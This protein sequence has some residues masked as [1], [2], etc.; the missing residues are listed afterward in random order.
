MGRRVGD[1]RWK[2]FGLLAVGLITLWAGPPF[3]SPA[4]A[5]WVLPSTRFGPDSTR[6]N[7]GYGPSDQISPLVPGSFDATALPLAAG[8]QFLGDA[9]GALRRDGFQLWETAPGQPPRRLA[10][11]VTATGW[12]GAAIASGGP[13][14][15][16]LTWA[17]PRFFSPARTWTVAISGH[18]PAPVSWPR[19]PLARQALNTVRTE[20]GESAVRY[21]RSLTLAAGRH[22]RYLAANGYQAPSFHRETAGQPEY[23]AATPWARDMMS[24]WP[25]PLTGEVGIES[26]SRLSGVAAVQTLIDTVSHRLALLSPNLLAEGWQQSRGP[27]GAWVMDLG[28]G[29]RATLPYAVVYPAPGQVGLPTGWTDVEAPNP[30]PAKPGA[31]LGYPVTVDFPTATRLQNI[32][33]TWLAGPALVPFYLDRPNQAGLG[34]N[35]IGLVPQRPLP[36]NSVFTVS[37]AADARYYD[38][39]WRPVRI[40]WRFATGGADQSVLAVPL[41]QA[42]LLVSVLQA[43]SGHPVAAAPVLVVRSGRAARR[44]SALA[45]G[46]TDRNGVAIIR[47]PRPAPAGRYDAITRTGNGVTFWWQAGQAIRQPA[48]SRSWSRAA[49]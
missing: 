27:Q 24:G 12:F 9:P 31:P 3:T 22:A 32:S 17:A 34:A 14:R 11:R 5:S 35:Q 43:G 44:R 25:S 10:A 1:N 28:Y 36:A 30:V 46:R 40:S 37:V 20:L 16:R 49:G 13:G 39:K 33:C 18:S 2:A 19:N 6:D 45:R 47:L 8:V 7:F 41:R 15:Y 26:A 29:Y 42:R 21:S 23:S 4:R 38:G 48:R